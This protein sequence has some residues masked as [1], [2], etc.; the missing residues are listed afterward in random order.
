MG[1]IQGWYPV[2]QGNGALRSVS[3]FMAA[4]AS[5]FLHEERGAR[6]RLSQ[7]SRRSR[8]SQR[9]PKSLKAKAGKKHRMRSANHVLKPQ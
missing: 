5:V 6:D 7:R 2:L 4:K 9:D 8:R 3:G 1:S